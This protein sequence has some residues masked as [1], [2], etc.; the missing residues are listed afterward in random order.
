M[1]ARRKNQILITFLALLMMNFNLLILQAEEAPEKEEA[2]EKHVCAVCTAQGNEMEVENL[3][4]KSLYKGETHYFCNEACKVKFD[5]DPQAFMPPV[6]P[7]PVPKFTVLDLKGKEVTLEKYKGKVVLLD[8]WATW[9]KPCVQAIPDLQK[10]HDELGKDKSFT[11]VG[12]S[13]DVGKDATKKVKKFIKKQK[14][15]YPILRDAKKGEAS[16]ALNVTA[17]PAMFLI[18]KEGQIIAQWVG[19]IDHEEVATKVS[20]LLDN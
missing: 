10:L 17:I 19:K 15:S 5:K 14:I 1:K 7:R 4:L 18:D 12:V 20:A 2:S 3:N 8:F 6:L 16:L 11:V 9:C 13:V